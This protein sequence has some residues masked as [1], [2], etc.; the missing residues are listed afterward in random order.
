MKTLAKTIL[1]CGAIGLTSGLTFAQTQKRGEV[2]DQEFIIRKDRILTVPTQPRMYEKLPILPQPTGLSDFTYYVS[3]YR[4]KLK[5]IELKPEAAQK[6]YRPER[7]DLYNGY[8]RAGYGNFDSPLLEARY[9][10]TSVSDFNYAVQLNH[11]SFGK[12]PLLAEQSKESH[13]NAGFDGSYFA[14]QFE[15]YGGLMWKQ[16]SYQFYGIDPIL[17]SEPALEILPIKG[18][19]QQSV[20]IKAGIRDIEKIGPFSYDGQ[21]SFRTFNDSYLA[22][23]AQF[24]VKASGSYRP[25]TDWLAKVGVSFYGTNPEDMTYSLSR[26]YLAIRPEVSYKYGEFDLTAGVN[27]IAENDSLEAKSSNLHVFPVLK[28]SYHFA[29][30]FGFFAE[31]SGDVN[32]NTY[33]S[34]V[35]ENPYLGSSDQLLNTIQ[36]YKIQGGIEGQFQGAFHY[37]AAVNVSRY[38]QL[39]FFVNNYTNNLE[40]TESEKFSVVYDDKSTVYT[41]NAEVGYKF[42]DIYQL[43]GRLDL[44]QYNLNTQAEAWHKPVWELRVNNQLT[45]IDRLLIQANLNFM[46]G[47]KARGNDLNDLLGYEG[48]SSGPFE[49]VNLKTIADL[50]LKADYGITDRISVFAEGNNILNGKNIRWLNYPVRGIQFVGGASFKF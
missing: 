2:T 17:F 50:Q 24:G 12:G 33:Y 8:V 49:V 6:I 48:L 28:A 13:T 18:T 21:L 38:N 9:M 15:V 35:T 23:E 14:N 34:F 7:L 44:N 27:L 16:N 45:P 19:V 39:Y 41:I 30:E 3:K 10:G 40:T 26:T 46:G 1:L 42:S 5:P 47:I 31:F 32:R 4:L 22:K 36:N 37:R 20:E 29:E 25:S 43:N 11:Q